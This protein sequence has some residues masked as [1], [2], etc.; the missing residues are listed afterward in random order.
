M[1]QTAITAAIL[2][3]ASLAAQ[4][5]IVNPASY[6]DKDKAYNDYVE[7]LREHD[8]HITLPQNFAPSSIRGLSDVRNSIGRG[9]EF[10]NIDC[11]PADIGAIV[12]DDSCR[13]A[14]CYPQ[15]LL[16][17]EGVPQPVYL[18]STRESGKIETDLRMIHDDMHLDVRPIVRIIAGEDM[19]QYAGADTAAFYEFD[20][21]RHSFMDTY[22]KGV[23]IYLRKKDH[24]AILLRLMLNDNS[25][26]EKDRYIREA[27][28]NIHFGNNPSETFAELEKRESG[29]PEFSFPTQYRMFTGILPDINDETLEEINRVK[30]WCE[31][32]GMKELPK[33]DD[34]VL[35]AL[36]RAKA[37][38]QR[39]YTEAD[40]ILAADISDNEK[41]LLPRMCDTKAH[42]PGD[43]DTRRKYWEWLD[44]NLRYPKAAAAKGIEGPI[45]VNFTVSADG[46][47]K[48]ISIS[49]KDR[50]ADASLKKEAI[51]LFE[52]MPRWTPATYKGNPVSTLESGIVNF[53]L[54]KNKTMEDSQKPAPSYVSEEHIYD[55]KSI[56]VGPKFNGGQEELDKWIQDHLQYPSGAAK[57]KIEGRVIVEFIIDK[58]GAVTM[59][60]VVRGINDSLNNE[61]L[62]VIKAL[63]RWTPG[64]ANGKP[65][66]A[67]YIYPVTFRLAKAK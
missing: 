11:Q 65:V 61:A 9:R 40:S 5:V 23:G 20:L 32:H 4:G 50:A 59:P 55:M 53:R 14:I 10:L 49:G 13:A 45:S 24:P 1:K 38:R 62:R 7:L 27:L 57:A 64:Y 36:N 19:S 52:S 60:K 35:D 66:K 33:L 47:L 43:G 22:T 3:L 18:G 48:D 34:A 37:S 46:S 56:T 63:P 39:D 6:K 17:I 25:F 29:R 44:K 42:F 58:N 51:R 8:V 16:D 2:L 28:D 21:P 67:R 31:E 15:I 54:P 30:A 26:K 12:E 41:I